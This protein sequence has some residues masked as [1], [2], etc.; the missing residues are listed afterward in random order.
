M[1]YLFNYAFSILQ[2][3]YEFVLMSKYPFEDSG[4]H[5]FINIFSMRLRQ[6]TINVVQ[7]CFIIC[8]FFFTICLLNVLVFNYFLSVK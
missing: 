3:S 6:L 4:F 5:L 2:M 8:C 1:Y 7:V